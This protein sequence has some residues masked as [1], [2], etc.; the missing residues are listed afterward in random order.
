MN[1]SLKLLASL[2][3][4]LTVYY[5]TVRSAHSGSLT[6]D[7]N[8]RAPFFAFPFGTR[9][10]LLPDGKYLS[11]YNHTTLTDQVT[12]A[13]TRHFADGT[14]DTSFTFSRDYKF[15]GAAVPAPGADG[16]III[17]ATIRSYGSEQRL[18][19]ILRLNA[20][21]SIDTSFTA[22]RVETNS[23]LAGTVEQIVIQPDGKIL[24]TGFFVT[25]GTGPSLFRL[26]PDGML[27][28]SFAVVTAGSAAYS[29]A[30]QPDG[31][32]LLG[33]NFTTVNGAASRG[34]ARLN[35]D[36]TSDLSF[37]TTAFTRGSGSPVRAIAV[38]ND[39]KIVLSGVFQFGTGISATRAPLFRVNSDGSADESF[40]Y[41][42]NLSPP[43][44]RGL[45]IQPDGRFVVCVGSSVYR[46]GSNGSLDGTFQPP[47]V[48]NT[49][50]DPAGFSGTP[51]SIN[52]QPD[53]R[54]LVD[55]DFSVVS[56]STRYSV[57]RL[58]SDGTLDPTFTT[59]HKPGF[60]ISPSSFSRLADGSTFV[61]F[62]VEF[63]RMDPEMPY[64]FGRLLV[65]G[66][67][68]GNFALAP[69]N[70]SGLAAPGFLTLGFDRFPD[71]SFFVFGTKGDFTR[72]YGKVS[73]GGNEESGFTFDSAAPSFQ[74]ALAL[75]DGKVLVSPET[76]AQS[77][78]EATLS[79]LHANGQLDSTF[80][81]PASIRSRQV[82]R[83]GSGN[84]DKIYVGS[85]TL[86]VQTDGKIIF[87]Y[88]A[89]DDLFHLV[90]LNADGSVDDSFIETPLPPSDLAQGF[91]SLYDPVTERSFQPPGGA[92]FA[93]V[94]LEDA[95]VLVDGRI[96]LVG[97][98]KS[99]NGVAAR[100]II[101]LN[102]D[103]TVDNSF[104]TGG[105][106]QW[107]ETTETAT[108]F[109]AVDNVE[110][111][112]DGRL[113]ITGTFEAFAG[114]PA[115]GI[116]SLDSNG[117]FDA[118]FSAPVV[119]DKYSGSNTFLARQLDDSFLISGP[120]H[121]LNG[122]VS[123]T[124][125][126]LVGLPV[127]TSPVAEAVVG[128]QFTYQIVA[129]NNPLS[130]DASNL[131][132]GLSF[133]SSLSA[134]VGTPTQAGTFQVSLSASNAQGTT[135]ATLTLTI[136]PAPTDGPVIISSTAATGRTGSPFRFQVITSGG[137]AATRL[138][139]T[140]LPAGL[141]FDPV[142]GLISGTAAFDGS[143]AVT[144]TVTDGN[145]TSSTTLQLTFT[146]DPELPVIISPSEAFVTAGQPFTY[147]IQ[148]PTSTPDDPVTYT[149]LGNLPPGL[150]FNPGT[151]TI[152]GT[153]T[154]Q[155]RQEGRGKPLSGGV[156]TN[157]QL[158]ATNSKGTTTKP[159]VFFLAPTGVVNISTRL[160]VQTGEN[161]LIG[162]FIVTGNA[163]K[164]VIIRGI[165]PSLRAGGELL[166]GSLQDPTLELRDGAG[167]LLG[168]NDDWRSNQEQEIIDT[169]I[170][171][172]DDREPA[173]IAILNPGPYTAVVSGKEGSTGIGLME[174]YDLGTAS[175]ESSSNA[176]LAN[177]S[178]RGFVQQGN[179]VMIGGF[180]VSG[181]A[182]KMI[183]R[184]IGPSLSE[185]GVAGAL[186]DTTLDLRDGNGSL[187]VSNDDWRTGG[188]EQQIID[189]TVPPSDDRE[190]AVVATLNP[191]PYTAVISG[192]DNTTG[193]ALV[194]AYV[195][196]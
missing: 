53:G 86:A 2:T 148:A 192:K 136:R 128:Q 1:N 134:I 3:I 137:S 9:T 162:G 180:I 193:V 187:I 90:R 165:G 75:A 89:S 133:N 41:V 185:R 124:L 116:A 125:I 82:I 87:L 145:F 135:N 52:L 172:S 99:F 70:A 194:E 152:S 184:A 84:V 151:G 6:V 64:N 170:P 177:I 94:A 143:T 190:S 29:L 166:Q 140:G 12:G 31:K 59:P 80:Q 122:G 91:A 155:S 5:P 160:A 17:A 102:A 101:R 76:N 159:L 173:L 54:I 189:T 36:G 154:V 179:D 98:F 71:G 44:G 4:A 13:L 112:A 38:Q 78:L 21:G 175:L 186:Q 43:N 127:I 196:Q 85:R 114:V 130:S 95:A 153:P 163:P 37:Q 164:R 61:G 30:L 142:S 77:I 47:V 81:I 131:P 96:V 48:R 167:A 107:T 56:S 92:F 88:L 147:T 27:D 149:L 111:Q 32:I 10:R 26:L 49:Y 34:L 109:P 22:T 126:R 120:Y 67:L 115:P 183:V 45:A 100:G 35:P 138:D 28:P 105:G 46:F 20:D 14:L 19:Q 104:A 139:A 15:V 8:F 188:Q 161:V 150:S 73:P 157:V 66:S 191:G 141:T 79:R 156:I 16:K 181:T 176:Q 39:G 178:T 171:P 58:N 144:L 25:S 117:S 60:D 106:A 121:R 195:L 24:I 7:E 65:D 68:D 55:G 118:S 174:F 57:A 169:T 168:S 93:T 40:L 83:D 129:T 108:S 146:S 182:A 97:K 72:T 123:P 42:T 69:V 50:V 62:S 132:P 119:R 113:L 51:V 110:Q 63:R 23:N 158:F 33:G 103:G 18:E 11:Y 74:K